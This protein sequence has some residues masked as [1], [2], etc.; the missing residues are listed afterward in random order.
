MPVTNKSKHNTQHTRR[1]G[2]LGWEWLLQLNRVGQ[3]QW[4][5]SARSHIPLF[6]KLIGRMQN[7]GTPAGKHCE[8]LRPRAA[9]FTRTIHTGGSVGT[10]PWETHQGHR[11]TSSKSTAE[12]VLTSL[13]LT[14]NLTTVIGL[15]WTGMKDKAEENHE[16]LSCHKWSPSGAPDEG[17]R[18]QRVSTKKGG[19]TSRL[20]N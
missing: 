19:S 10:A 7:R 15:S 13:Y 16:C 12:A 1:E 9:S 14:S 5:E 4:R 17:Q 6:K 18:K 3:L 20:T 2:G 8:T 11:S